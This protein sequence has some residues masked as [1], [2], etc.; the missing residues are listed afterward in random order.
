MSET[1]EIAVRRAG[2]A[3]AVPEKLVL[4]PAQHQLW[5]MVLDS[6][7]SEHS[8]RSYAK[9]LDLLFAFAAS[10]PLTRALLMEYGSSTEDLAPS[11]GQS[12]AGRSP[13][14]GD[15][16][17][18]EGLLSSEEAASLTDVPTSGSRERALETGSR[19]SRE[20]NCCRFRIARR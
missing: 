6:V 2:V 11:N 14:D 20:G 18:A 17:E 10:R 9:A 15:G 12:P 7:T 3:L 1:A 8:R 13:Q 4:T 16:S 19:K 5:Q